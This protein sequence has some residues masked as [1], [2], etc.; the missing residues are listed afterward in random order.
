MRSDFKRPGA[1]QRELWRSIV[2]RVE[3]DKARANRLRRKTILNRRRSR[4]LRSHLEISR[5]AAVA[6]PGE[7]PGKEKKDSERA[8]V[9]Q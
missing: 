7:L 9:E 8:G 6:G 5:Q 1:G 2:S 3:G 4:E